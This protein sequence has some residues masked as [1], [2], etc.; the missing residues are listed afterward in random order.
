MLYLLYFKRISHPHHS[1]KTHPHV[2]GPV[3]MLI[4]MVSNTAARARCRD[5]TRAYNGAITTT[6]SGALGV[7]VNARLPFRGVYTFVPWFCPF[8]FIG[9]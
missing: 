4:K 3:A 7:A 2:S 5:M 1:T 6:N 9:F 8:S